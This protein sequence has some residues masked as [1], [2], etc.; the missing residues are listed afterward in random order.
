[1]LV[2]NFSWENGNLIL[3]VFSILTENRNMMNLWENSASK[4]NLRNPMQRSEFLNS[5]LYLQMVIVR[6]CNFFI[7]NKHSTTTRSFIRTIHMYHSL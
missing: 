3:S 7:I 5:F 1:M 4:F 2:S 6:Q